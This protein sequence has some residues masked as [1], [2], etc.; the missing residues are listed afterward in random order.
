[1]SAVEG[2]SGMAGRQI[3]VSGR[4]SDAISDRG[5]DGASLTLDYDP[6]GGGTFIPLPAELVRRGDG[7]FG[8][9]IP[10]SFLPQPSGATPALRLAAVAPGHGDAAATLPISPEAL[11]LAEET[12]SLAGHEVTIVRIDGAP[13]RIDL[14][15]DPLPVA[16][17]GYVLVEGDSEQPAAGAE[18]KVI[19]PA[20]PVTIADGDGSFR[21]LA[22]PVAAEMTIRVSH[23]GD[24]RDHFFRPDYAQRIN[25]AVFATA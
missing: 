5:I 3:L 21:L 25:R 7:W 11:D 16:L 8:F 13:F 2:L 22:L 10:P 12:R 15:L 9:H 6:S 1:M 14:V 19:D 20:G 4:C 23:D 17:A 18:I 24:S